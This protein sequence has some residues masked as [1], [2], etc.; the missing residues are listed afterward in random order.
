MI[1]GFH[2]LIYSD[3]PDATRTFFRDVLQ[4]PW[5]DAHG[6]W[7]IFKTPPSEAGVH[8]IDGDKGQRLADTPFHQV[9]L[10]CDDLQATVVELREKGV[11]VGDE[12][13]D[14]GYGIVTSF[15]VPG[16]GWM[17]LYQPRHPLAY[18]LEG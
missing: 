7:L 15:Q 10:M 13:H 8:P 18:E 2:T 6:G 17:Q 12:I 16:A 4:W 14:E 1:N 11:E 5:L 9:S 3:D